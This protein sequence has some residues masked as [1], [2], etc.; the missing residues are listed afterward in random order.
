MFKNKYGKIWLW[1]MRLRNEVDE[2]D[3]Q[4]NTIILVEKYICKVEELLR[5]GKI[6]P[7]RYEELIKNKIK[8]LNKYKDIV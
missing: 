3:A 5:N 8:F 2:L 4:E 1:D 7:E 6:S